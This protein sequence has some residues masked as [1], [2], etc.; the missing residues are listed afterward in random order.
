MLKRLQEIM[1]Y[2]KQFF[3]LMVGVPSYE[4]YVEHMKAHHPNDN[5]Q[6]RGE[7]FC[8]VQESRYSGKDGKISRCC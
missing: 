7:F 8:E 5:I 6:T 1:K 2:R 3:S 4:K